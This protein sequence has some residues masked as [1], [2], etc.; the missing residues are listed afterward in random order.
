MARKKSEE[1]GRVNE[2]IEE[3]YLHRSQ[4]TRYSEERDREIR[5]RISMQHRDILNG[6]PTPPQDYE[7]YWARVDIR[8][9]EPDLNRVAE[10]SSLGWDP[11]P[12]AR[13][14]QIL[15]FDVLG[16]LANPRGYLIVRG[17][18]LME[19]HIKYGELERQKLHS[20][21]EETMNSIPY[22]DQINVNKNKVSF[23]ALPGSF[24]G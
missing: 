8:E 18:M 11:V 20:K 4:D 7:Y 9:G 23:G 16:R 3:G 2:R 24:G 14:P 13:H 12:S 6:T 21:N 17:L 15:E 10:L 5:K 19:R 1:R 22:A